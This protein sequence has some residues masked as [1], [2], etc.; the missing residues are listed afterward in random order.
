MRDKADHLARM[1]A[2]RDA[3]LRKVA[4]RV[5]QFGELETHLNT[6]KSD[7]ALL[8]VDRTT[9]RVRSALLRCLRLVAVL[10]GA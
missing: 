8:P 4:D 3:C 5:R 1:E 9:A 7:L 2:H 10:R 6:A